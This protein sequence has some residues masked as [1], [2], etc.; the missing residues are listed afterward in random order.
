VRHATLIR[1]SDRRA[2]AMSSRRIDRMN[3]RRR[4]KEVAA[5]T[6]RYSTFSGGTVGDRF[7][8]HRKGAQG[9]GC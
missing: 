1:K 3:A 8:A 7:W 4:K 6:T 2:G 5:A 9:S